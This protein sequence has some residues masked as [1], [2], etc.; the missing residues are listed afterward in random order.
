LQ[1]LRSKRSAGCQAKQDQHYCYLFCYKHYFSFNLAIFNV[2]N[3][4]TN[5]AA[6]L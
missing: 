2:D 1:L 3:N 6:L 5:A 4:G